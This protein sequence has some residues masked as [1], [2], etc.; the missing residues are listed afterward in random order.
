M[1]VPLALVPCHTFCL[2]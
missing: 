1:W 2:H